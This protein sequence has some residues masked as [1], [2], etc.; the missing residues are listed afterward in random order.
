MKFF[1]DLPKKIAEIYE[2]FNEIKVR[3]DYVDRDV[4]NNIDGFKEIVTDFEKRLRELER[5]AVMDKAEM[6]SE[7]ASLKTMLEAVYKQS[8][9][10]TMEKIA[11]E[12]L[13]NLQESQPD[14]S[15]ST[16]S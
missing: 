14:E 12:N 10:Q 11:A 15:P 5:Q 4:K 2:R 9:Q 3:M 7:I 1:S 8:I 6:K 13:K 16:K